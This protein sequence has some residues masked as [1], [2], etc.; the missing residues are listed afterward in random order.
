[1]S[2]IEIRTTVKKHTIRALWLQLESKNRTIKQLE[3]QIKELENWKSNHNHALSSVKFQWSR[4]ESELERLAERL[5]GAQDTAQDAA[6][7]AQADSMTAGV[8]KTHPD[9]A[10]LASQLTR[11]ELDARA[12]QLAPSFQSWLQR[13]WKLAGLKWAKSDR[14][15]RDQEDEPQSED[16]SEDEEEED[17]SDVDD[18]GKDG[19]NME[20]RLYKLDEKLVRKFHRDFDRRLAQQH[21]TMLKCL[22]RILDA[23]ASR[24]GQLKGA[25][26]DASAE[27]RLKELAAANEALQSECE[28]YKLLLITARSKAAEAQM[29]LEQAQTE[30]ERRARAEDRATYASKYGGGEASATSPTTVGGAS[31]GGSTGCPKCSG[32]AGGSEQ[33]NSAAVEA[34]KRAAAAA[35]SERDAATRAQR[36]IQ[37]EKDALAAEVDL[38]KK[39]ISS[40]EKELAQSKETLLNAMVASASSHG[41]GAEHSE[42]HAQAQRE[43]IESVTA[44]NAS[45]QQELSSLA[46]RRAAELDAITSAQQAAEKEFAEF[47]ASLTQQLHEAQ[48]ARLEALAERDAL[49]ASLNMLRA[50]GSELTSA[51]YRNQIALLEAQLQELKQA[52]VAATDP[53]LTNRGTL[54]HAFI[55]LRVEA[56]RREAQYLTELA[57]LRTQL[58]TNASAMT[59]EAPTAS[60]ACM[61][62]Q[63]AAQAAKEVAEKALTALSETKTREEWE[64]E[65]QSNRELCEALTTELNDQ[66]PAMQAAQSEISRLRAQVRHFDALFTKL[67]SE[68]FGA[69]HAQ[70]L[71]RE[72]VEA[73]SRRAIASAERIRALEGQLAAAEKKAQTMREEAEKASAAKRE[74]Q[75][76]LERE[77]HELRELMANQKDSSPRIAE[78]TKQVNNLRQAYTSEHKQLEQVQVELL[79]AQSELVKAKVRS[80]R[81]KRKVEELEN[82]LK[83]QERLLQGGSSGGAPSAAQKALLDELRVVKSKLKCSVCSVREKSV[84]LTKC[85]HTFCR[86]CIEHTIA[87]RQRKCP[88]CARPFGVTD[89]QNIYFT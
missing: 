84:V 87:S 46:A 62:A 42:P 64:E 67:T 15:I 51:Q 83:E 44:L 18:A 47:R 28:E 49:Q 63:A 34:A 7:G 27:K 57:Q 59:A 36:D 22:R 81:Y 13:E 52:Q 82:T 55:K 58:Q 21:Q 76:Q 74:V 11:S 2:E 68:S 37:S 33:A 65:A 1:M 3:G 19:S 75:L 66:E 8:N 31:S 24:D 71:L 20:V 54:L 14:E 40:L 45:L 26:L 85:F 32:E 16:E 50:M 6:S 88:G 35:Q 39:R 60:D 29:Q 79:T 78:L 5:D 53:A 4:L 70:T 30:L 77:R 10:K 61:R 25:Q 9:D 41:H 89:V 23:V 17:E 48:Q 86:E 43:T 12:L 69:S 73:L 80:D 56:A 72:Q 38:L